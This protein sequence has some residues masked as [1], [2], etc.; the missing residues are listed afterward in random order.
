MA[1]KKIY[2]L[3]ESLDTGLRY[4]VLGR[5]EKFRKRRHAYKVWKTLKS[6]GCTVYPVASDFKRWESAKVYPD[7]ASLKNKVDIVVPCLQPEEIPNFVEEAAA[8]GVK[9]IWFQEKTW[10]PEF[11]EQCDALGI[12][13]VRGCVLLHKVYP[14]PLGYLNPCYWH[15]L[16]AIKVPKK[17]F[18]K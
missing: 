1:A 4:A 15:G 3:T 9:Q 18:R 8:A 2:P 7:L 16:K 13:V 17:G 11:Q 6:F 5:A 10:T 14:K 12:I